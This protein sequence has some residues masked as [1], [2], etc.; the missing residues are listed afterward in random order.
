[1]LH[2]SKSKSALRKHSF[3]NRVVPYWNE[4]PDKVKEA[5]SI[6]SF[7]RRL[8]KYWRVYKIKYSYDNCIEFE[9]QRDN[10]NYAGT[11]RKNV[12]MTKEE[13]L[14]LKAL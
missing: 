14:A 10:P 9:K 7:E 13:D 5:P 6:K 1:M 11:G 4:L 8:D 2:R 12:K 3:H